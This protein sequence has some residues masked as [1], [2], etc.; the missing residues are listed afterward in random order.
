MEIQEKR[1][2][3]EREAKEQQM[4]EAERRAKS[5]ARSNGR[6]AQRIPLN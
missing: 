5:A 1:L 2:E 6:G 4:K 3:V